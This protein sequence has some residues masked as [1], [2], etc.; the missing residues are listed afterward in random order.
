MIITI[1]DIVTILIIL[2]LIG[3]IIFINIKNFINKKLTDITINIP[4][5][6]VPDPNIVVKIQKKL[7]MDFMD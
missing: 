2:G 7:S 4:P 3:V 5:F 1:L 6:E